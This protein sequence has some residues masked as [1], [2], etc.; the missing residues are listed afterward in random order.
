MTISMIIHVSTEVCRLQS[1]KSIER[2][3]YGLQT[4]TGGNASTIKGQQRIKYCLEDGLLQCVIE[5]EPKTKNLMRNK[6]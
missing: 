2:K 1:D 5:I 6:E 4:K 3:I